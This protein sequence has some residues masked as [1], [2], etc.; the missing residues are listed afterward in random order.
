MTVDEI[1][2][3]A[4]MHVNS[5]LM[6]SSAKFALYEAKALAAEGEY[7]FARRRALKSLA[8]SV[9]GFH[10]DYQAIE[11]LDADSGAR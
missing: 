9:G 8:Y 7:E 6:A 11:R 1:I 3:I 4:E 5:G 2:A 10:P